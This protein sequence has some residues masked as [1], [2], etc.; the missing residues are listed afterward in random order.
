MYEHLLADCFK[1]TYS[2]RQPRSADFS[3]ESASQ[4]ASVTKERNGHMHI[5]KPFLFSSVNRSRLWILGIAGGLC[6]VGAERAA[7]EGEEQGR[8][9]QGRLRLERQF[10]GCLG[11]IG[12]EIHRMLCCD[13][14]RGRGEALE[15]FYFCDE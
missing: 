9:L 7:A 1:V 13:S 12:C 3:S 5:Q 6:A 14:S 15:K 11:S 4:G 2:D 10:R 8:W